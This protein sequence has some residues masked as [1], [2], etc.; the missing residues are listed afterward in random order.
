LG[1][2]LVD[3]CGDG[4]DLVADSRIRPPTPAPEIRSRRPGVRV[5]VQ[6]G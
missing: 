3:A 4:R 6:T 1:A 2:V 5:D